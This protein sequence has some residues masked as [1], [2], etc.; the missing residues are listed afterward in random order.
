MTA[1]A[2]LVSTNSVRCGLRA[3]L[4]TW[5]DVFR[6]E[7]TVSAQRYLGVLFIFVE[8]QTILG[9]RWKA[10]GGMGEHPPERQGA[11]ART[12]RVS[13]WKCWALRFYWKPGMQCLSRTLPQV[14]ADIIAKNRTKETFQCHWQIK[15][16]TSVP[17]EGSSGFEARLEDSRFQLLAF[18]DW[19][20]WQ[21]LRFFYPS[22][23]KK[24]SDV[25]HALEISYIGRMSFDVW[26]LFNICQDVDALPGA[27]GGIPRMLLGCPNWDVDSVEFCKTICS[28]PIFLHPKSPCDFFMS[29]LD[30]IVLRTYLWWARLFEFPVALA[31]F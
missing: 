16:C 2:S 20:T 23:G 13:S 6:L 22:T 9:S 26:R 24:S 11:W 30:W 31:K 8:W 5:F 21:A 17:F 10:P 14:C 1:K 27:A 4:A 19:P 15:F 29:P 28:I 25:E 7:M 3:H 12:H 18:K